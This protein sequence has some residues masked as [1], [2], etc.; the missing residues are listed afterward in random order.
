MV[1]N[2]W[3]HSVFGGAEQ[4]VVVSCQP[5]QEAQGPR[6]WGWVW[7]HRRSVSLC[8]HTTHALVLSPSHR[9]CLTCTNLFTLCR[10]SSMHCL[11]PMQVLE[12][13]QVR[14]RVRVVVWARVPV[15]AP[16]PV[17]G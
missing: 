11:V 7:V 13:G 4:S 2:L 17:R 16:Q 14:V 8:F 12:W 10:P 5:N 1:V 15:L 3:L 9:T 6:G